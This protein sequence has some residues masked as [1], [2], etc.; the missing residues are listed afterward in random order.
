MTAPVYFAMGGV[1]FV[2]EHA[3]VTMERAHV[4]RAIHQQNA[5]DWLANTD[6]S[7]TARLGMAKVEQD[8]ADEM[9]AA[10]REVGAAPIKLGEAA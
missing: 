3:A 5:A 4:I 7:Q 2:R 9:S 6:R 8:L 1:I 10:I